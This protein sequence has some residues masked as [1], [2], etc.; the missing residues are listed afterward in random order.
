VHRLLKRQ[1]TRLF[2]GN[3]QPPGLDDLLRVVD[4]TYRQYDEDR[5][6]TERSLELGSEELLQRN[7][8]LRAVLS[9]FPDSFFWL[10]A[11][12][13]VVD[14]KGGRNPRYN[15]PTAEVLGRSIAEIPI[16][17]R[18]ELFAPALRGLGADRDPAELEYAVEL[19]GR[20]EH[21][22]ARLLP[23]V[24]GKVLAIVRNITRRKA[25]EAELLRRRE[26]LEQRVAERTAELTAANTRYKAAKEEAERANRAKTDFLSMVSHE[27]RT[28]L[29]SVV[30]FAKMVHK[31]LAEH[32]FP[33]LPLGD[34]RTDR[35]VNQV[36]GNLQIMVSEG[37]RLTDLINDVLDIAKLEAGKVVFRMENLPV[38]LLVNRATEAT[39]AL[40]EQKGLIL[41]RDCPDSLPAVLGDRDRLLQVLINLL[42]NAVKFTDAGTVRCA[43]RAGDGVVQMSVSDTGR[44]IAPVDQTRIFEKF[45]QIG[46]TLTDRPGGSGLGLAICRQIVEQ[47]GGVIWVESEPGKG[48]TFAFTL[49]VTPDATEDTAPDQEDI[50]A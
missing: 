29:T 45:Q 11:A 16:C 2:R 6:L 31:R 13:Q 26:E 20:E 24:R 35:V 41:V 43:A 19:H 23:L 3:G 22:E 14:Y 49:P 34:S 25:A 1:L 46:D 10:D 18:P 42:S 15:F 17:R 40:F 21:F 39:A 12:G 28:P 33:R 44:G 50:R 30:G 38:R 47:H 36:E 9:A 5:E 8:E 48:S 37:D 4:E 32:V 27:L 7:A